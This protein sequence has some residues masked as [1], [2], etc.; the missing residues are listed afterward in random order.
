[1]GKKE[2]RIL[3][4][5]AVK[6]IEQVTSKLPF[7][8][9]LTKGKY[10]DLVFEF[11]E[12]SVRITHKGI[13]LR[14]FSFV[15][16]SSSWTSRDLAYAVKLYLE[17]NSV[18]CTYVE[19]GTSKITDHLL[20]ALQ[21]VRTPNTLFIDYKQ[22]QKHLEKIREV[23]GYP[24]IVKDTKGSKGARSILVEGERYLIKALEGL[25]K[26]K[27][28]LFQKYIFNEYDWG[29]MVVN[30]QVVSGEKSYPQIGEF[31]N[32]TCNGAQEVF[33]DSPDDIPNQIKKMA[34]QSSKALKLSWSRS[35]IIVDK[36][37]DI[38]YLMEVNRLPGL[39]SNS[40][41]I[42]GAYAFLSSHLEG[43]KDCFLVK[44]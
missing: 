14:D 3:V 44:D 18:R 1:M 39:T 9:Y 21:G 24:L 5:P 32:N 34:L 27:K 37:T 38:P 30:D 33:V 25:P 43:V 19:K 10:T 23:C 16:L 11:Q 28:Y 7:P 41:E 26:H 13:D 4:L 6:N 42:D 17:W 15:W 20:F 40:M 8:V 31:R 22:A 2:F 36:D 29:V 12:G 35:D